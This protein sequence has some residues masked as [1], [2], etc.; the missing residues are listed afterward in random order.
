MLSFVGDEKGKNTKIG[1]KRSVKFIILIN[2]NYI[3]AKV[4]EK[5]D[6]R[7]ENSSCTT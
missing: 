2:Y 4:T 1:I 7:D 3:C 6:F 5:S